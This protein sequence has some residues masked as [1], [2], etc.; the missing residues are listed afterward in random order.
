MWQ[1]RFGGDPAVIGRSL[2][3]NGESYTIIGVLPATFQFALRAA[4]LWIP[5]QPTQ[6]QLTRRFLHGTN[7]IG[8]LKPGIGPAEAQSELN[9]IA[10]RIEHSSTIRTRARARASFLCRKKWSE[11]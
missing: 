4:D 9:L 2:N 11:P 1:R 8:R 7:L 10:G 3:I 5:Y 6:N